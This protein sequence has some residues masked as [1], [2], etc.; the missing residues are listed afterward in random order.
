MKYLLKNLNEQVMVITGASSGIGL[1][2]ARAAAKRGTKMVLAARNEDALRRLTEELT[3]Q[4]CEAIYVVADVGDEEQ[5]RSIA[6][7]AIDRFGGFDTWVNNAGV[8]I[9]G[10]NEDISLKDH[11]Q[12]FQTNFWGVVHGSLTAVKHLRERGGGALINLGSEVSDHVAPLQGMYSTS[13]HAVK[14]FTNSLRL[15]LEEEKAPISVTLIKPAAIDTMFVPHAKNYLDVVPRLP[16]PVYAPEIVAEAILYAAEH[17]KRDIY[18]GGASKM[19]SS[20]S[21]FAP[22]LL[23]KFMA[24]FGKTMTTTDQPV[25]GRD[26]HS[27]YS[28]S[29]GCASAKAPIRTSSSRAST[30]RQPSIPTRR[31]RS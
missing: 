29:A 26:E 12:L 28:P 30:R 1:T 16:P 22:G 31:V 15:E 20:T 2:T 8:S 21:R 4:D 18:V 25:R 9:F 17:P 11:R 5:V 13:K 3:Q 19:L 24:R 10:R 27:L 23:D 7:A 14:G 6:K